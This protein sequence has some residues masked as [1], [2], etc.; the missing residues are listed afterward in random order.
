VMPSALRIGMQEVTGSIGLLRFQHFEIRN[1]DS[2][3][4]TLGTYTWEI[5]V[6]YAT[7]N[8]RASGSN[9]YV[10]TLNFQGVAGIGSGGQGFDTS[11]GV[12]ISHP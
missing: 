3:N 5:G 8:N 2:L 11:T 6:T 7:P 12:W 9:V 1:Q 4:F 10:N